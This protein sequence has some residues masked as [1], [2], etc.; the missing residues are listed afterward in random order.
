MCAFAGERVM[1]SYS[2]WYN[3]RQVGACK[4]GEAGQNN[5]NDV[6]GDMG[7]VMLTLMTMMRTSRQFLVHSPLRI[8]SGQ[9]TS[10]S[11]LT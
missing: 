2:M 7:G 4:T 1:L 6:D 5:K 10:Q 9:P 11:C 3:I 8:V